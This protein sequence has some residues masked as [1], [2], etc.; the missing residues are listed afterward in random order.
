MKLRGHM[1]NH[2]VRIF[3][4]S[5]GMFKSQGGQLVP[6]E[7]VASSAN[8]LGVGSVVNVTL[9]DVT[10][11]YFDSPANEDLFTC[12]LPIDSIQPIH[13]EPQQRVYF[14]D[15]ETLVWQVGRVL[16]YQSSDREYLIR[17]PNKQTR[18]IP[19]DALQT[20][21]ASPI[22][23]PTDHLALQMNETPF[24]H[25]GRREFIRNVFAQRRAC[26][27]IPALLSSSVDLVEH[28]VAVVRH[29]LLDPFQRYLL[30]D[31]VGLGKTIEAGIL[32][33]QYVL[34]DPDMHSVLVIVPEALRQQ[35]IGELRH[36]FH[37][38]D[39]LDESVHVVGHRQADAI[40]Q[41]GQNAGMIVIDEAHHVAAWARSLDRDKANT[42]ALVS[43]ITR[44]Q[45]RRVLLLSATPVLH[46]EWA[47]LAML[48]LIDPLVYSLDDFEAFRER[49]R[50]RQEIAELLLSLTEDES[51]YFLRQTLDEMNELFSED[52]RFQ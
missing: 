39:H 5:A 10:V 37:L 34:D 31:E 36:R 49:V 40:R 7:F 2:P 42:F 6:G 21:W 38:D 23:D 51:N 15:P 17:F 1:H 4:S 50:N 20:R 24:W 30:A 32:I 19:E 16:H 29:V 46:N 52:E 11:D 18:L 26:G 22:E 41:I 33:R 47:F 14:R 25:D 3:P 28:Q 35:W 45:E 48:N 8:K 43:Q 9:H 44:P 13:L 12:E 27:G